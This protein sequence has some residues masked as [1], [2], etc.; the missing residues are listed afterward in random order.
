VLRIAGYFAAALHVRTSNFVG[1]A[2]G[3]LVGMHVSALKFKRN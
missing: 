1:L 2:Q 3:N